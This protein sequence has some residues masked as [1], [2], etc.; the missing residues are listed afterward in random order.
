MSARLILLL[1]VIAMGGV[2]GAAAVAQQG[3]DG[4]VAFTVTRG[5][6]ASIAVRSL[7][8]GPQRLVRVP[9]LRGKPVDVHSIA[10]SAR[11]GRFAFSD[12]AGRIFVA[13]ASGTGLRLVAAPAG[14]DRRYVTVHGWSPNGRLL[15]V[16]TSVRGCTAGEPRLLAVRVDGRGSRTLSAHPAGAPAATARNPAFIE[17]A[18]WSPNGSELVYAWQQYRNG[19]CRTM[20]GSNRPTRVLTIG[21]D[22]TRRRP[23]A[24]RDLLFNAAWSPS[25]EA[26]ALAACGLGTEPLAWTS[27]GRAVAIATTWDYCTIWMLQRSPLQVQEVVVNPSRQYDGEPG[28]VLYNFTR[29]EADARVLRALGKG[30]E[31]EAIGTVPRGAGVVART[32]D[33]LRIIP[34]DGSPLVR[35][36][37]LR[38][39]RGMVVSTPAAAGFTG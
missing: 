14:L 17:L 36:P 12:S 19:D 34:L 4:R 3:V 32:G 29:G 30:T 10:W 23:I 22:G 33:G 16:T 8:G 24:Q 35:L 7:A 26:I 37:P 1:G 28:T 2:P 13:A 27:D 15:A 18:G 31:F 25:G 38:A 11:A 5:K 20:G 21:A 39:P 6:V 9:R